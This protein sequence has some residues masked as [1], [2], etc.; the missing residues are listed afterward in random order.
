MDAS[1]RTW[2]AR[3]LFGAL[4]IGVWAAFHLYEQWAA[5]GGREPFVERLSSTS[6]GTLALV[7][8]LALGVVHVHEHEHV[9]K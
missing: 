7:T 1:L 2:R 8:E 6:H 4:G 5:F 3:E 9:N